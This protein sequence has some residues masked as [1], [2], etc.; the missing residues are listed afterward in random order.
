[1][2]DKDIENGKKLVEAL[3]ESKFILVGALWFYFTDSGEWRLLLVSPLADTIGP[4][5]CYRVIQSVLGDM[6]PGLGISLSRISVSS[7]RDNLFR[8]LRVAI[9]TGTG[10]STIRFTRGTING[11]FIEDALIYRLV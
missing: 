2:V 11:V 4:S 6:S 1:L 10:I 3:D 7:P 5:G 9:R 8:L